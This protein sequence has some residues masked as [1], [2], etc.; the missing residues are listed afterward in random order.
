MGVG[1][2][3][4]GRGMVTREGN[5]KRRREGVARERYACGAIRRMRITPAIYLPCC[6]QSSRMGACSPFVWPCRITRSG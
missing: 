6:S 4:A 3:L 2:F 1:D 5:K